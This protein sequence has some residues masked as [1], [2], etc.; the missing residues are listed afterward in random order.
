MAVHRRCHPLA[1]PLLHRGLSGWPDFAFPPSLFEA[2]LERLEVQIESGFPVGLALN[3]DFA[4]LK[5][6]WAAGWRLI[7]PGRPSHV[8][9]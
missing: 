4:N 6:D 5:S 1:G 2:G 9:R 8:H 3:A 7:S